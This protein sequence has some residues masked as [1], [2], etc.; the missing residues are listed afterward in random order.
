MSTQLFAEVQKGAPLKHTDTVDKSAPLVEPGV[1]IKQN[2]HGALL[3]EISAD[4]KLAHA[5][6]VDKS[7][8][9]IDSSVHIKE[10]N[11]ASL[12]SDIKAKGQ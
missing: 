5:E 12:L 1:T 6:T 10:N 4:H 3:N 8:P 9:V 11:R 7:A 2:Q